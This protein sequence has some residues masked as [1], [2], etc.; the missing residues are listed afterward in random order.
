MKI[1]YSSPMC[2]I[3]L[4]TLLFKTF[5]NAKL[6]ACMYFFIGASAATATSKMMVWS[7]SDEFSSFLRL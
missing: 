1:S 5:M 2:G 4:F 7:K 6:S 3:F